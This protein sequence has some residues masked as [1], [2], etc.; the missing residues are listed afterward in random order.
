[1]DKENLKGIVPALAIGTII[2]LALG[3]IGRKATEQRVGEPPGGT[4]RYSIPWARSM[5]ISW[6]PEYAAWKEGRF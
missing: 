6:T 3:F 2:V 1:M 4:D 5:T